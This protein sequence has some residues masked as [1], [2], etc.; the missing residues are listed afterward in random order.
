MRVFTLSFVKTGLR[1]DIVHMNV[2]CTTLTFTQT[3][4]VHK[5]RKIFPNWTIDRV[6]LFEQHLEDNKDNRV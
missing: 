2:S 5:T 1:L 4:S 3:F 6:L